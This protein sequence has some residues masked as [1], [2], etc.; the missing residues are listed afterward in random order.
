MIVRRTNC[1]IKYAI[2]S[3]NASSRTKDFLTDYVSNL[4]DAV[5]LSLPDEV[6][7]LSELIVTT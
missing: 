5:Y 4:I 1:N 7:L 6:T 3:P 2:F